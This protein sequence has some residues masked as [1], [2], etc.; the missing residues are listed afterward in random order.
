MRWFNDPKVRQYLLMYK[1]MSKAREKRWFE[2]YL[3][4]F[5]FA[6]RALIEGEWEGGSSA[7]EELHLK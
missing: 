5:L 2:A 1:S 4:D 7:W 3:E 6:V